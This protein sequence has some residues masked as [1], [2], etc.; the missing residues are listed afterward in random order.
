MIFRFRTDILKIEE[1]HF[2]LLEKLKCSIGVPV[3]VVSNIIDLFY[4]ELELT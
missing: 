3:I 4:I 1:K 2:L